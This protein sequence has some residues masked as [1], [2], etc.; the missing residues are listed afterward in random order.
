MMPPKTCTFD[1]VYCQ[2]GKTVNKV[3]KPEDVRIPVAA[4]KVVADLRRALK[5]DP[6]KSIDYVT[7]SGFGEPTLNLQLGD[8]V[9]QVKSLVSSKPVA[10]LTNASLVHRKDVRA[11]LAQCLAVDYKRGCKSNSPHHVPVWFF[12]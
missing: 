7:F 3:S 6:S 11:N 4:K 8:M 10:V 1:C 2:L 5:N 12:L 9:D